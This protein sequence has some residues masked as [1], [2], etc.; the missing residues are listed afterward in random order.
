MNDDSRYIYVLIKTIIDS[1]NN[2]CRNS[3]DYT[4]T[5]ISYNQLYLELK[6]LMKNE[7]NKNKI[8]IT[9]CS[10][11]S[12]SISV[13]PV[14]NELESNIII[15]PNFKLQCEFPEYKSKLKVIKF[16][17]KLNYNYK[18]SFD[19]LINNNNDIKHQILL[20]KEQFILIGLELIDSELIT[21]S[22][23]DLEINKLEKILKLIKS[24]LDS[25][26]VFIDIDLSIFDQSLS[27]LCLRHPD[28]INKIEER[29]NIDKLQLRL[30]LQYLSKLNICGIN[31]S[32]FCVDFNDTS[33]INRIQ[34]ETIHQIYG[35]LLNIKQHKINIFNENSRF[36][37]FKP[38]EEIYDDIDQY[39][40][41][42][43][44]NIDLELKEKLLE[45]IK[46]GEI[47]SIEIDDDN[48]KKK[49]LISTTTLS[50]Q[51]ELS[52]YLA[53]DYSDKR[54]YPDEKLDAYF[55]LIV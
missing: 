30:F 12:V 36:L 42:I 1:E 52:Y 26:P 17:S 3:F 34:I 50:D 8:L 23:N 45:D 53:E 35:S 49:I 38:Q 18:N 41:Y 47:I 5:F 10:D 9:F 15:Q 46:D 44:R 7:E 11:P 29:V 20:K 25:N 24:N 19:K 55:N 21:Y 40:W 22:K 33:L 6:S 39:G 51:D 31:I 37:I 2:Y 4:L 54:L 43:M 32:G 28:E 14:L 13:I 27:P 48:I 16:T